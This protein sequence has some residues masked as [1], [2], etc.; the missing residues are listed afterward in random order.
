MA[1]MDEEAFTVPMPLFYFDG[2]PYT[3]VNVSTNGFITFGSYL[4]FVDWN[5]ISDSEPYDGVVAAFSGD[6]DM[7]ASGTRNIRC[8]Q[9]GNEFVIQWQNVSRYAVSGERISFQIR[10]NSA[11]G[12]I[13]VVYGGTITPGDDQYY[14][15]IG[16]RG[17]DNTF[18]TNVNN[19]EVLTGPWVSSAPGVDRFSTLVFD[20][21]DP[22]AVPSAGTTFT[23]TPA[24]IDMIA[25]SLVAPGTL[26]CYGTNETVTV[27]I[28]NI[29]SAIMNFATT[30]VTVNASASGPNPATFAPVVVNTG[31]L[32]PGA[33]QTVV[34]TTT[35][36]MS[37]AG[38]YSFDASV[39]V[40][41]D[42]RP[43][44]DAMAT[45]M[46]N[47]H[48]PTVAMT[49]NLSMCAGG[50]VT[51]NANAT[52]HDYS[53]AFTNTTAVAIPDEDPV[54]VNSTIVIS[55]Q[56]VPA[57]SVAVV[58]H[59]IQHSYISD[60]TLTLTAPD[61]ST[62][63]LFLEAGGSDPDMTE[64]RFIASAVTPISTGTAPFTGDYLPE[65]PF[66]QLTGLANGTWT[67]NVADNYEDD[68]GSLLSWSIEI[69]VTNVISTYAWSPAGS[70]S[71]S[72]VSN[73]DASPSATETYT[74][75]VT[76]LS[77][78]T[79][80][81]EV[82]V[83]V[84]ALPTVSASAS[85]TTVCENEAVTFNGSG[86]N[87]YAWTGGV[88][89]NVPFPVTVTDTYTVTGTDA[90]GCTDTDEITVTVIP[91][92]TVIATA[93]ATSVCDGTPVT[94]TG[95]GT[96]TTYTWDNS[97]I[98]ATPFTPT[99][100]TTYVVTGEDANGCE[101]T[102]MITVTVNALPTV[103]ATASSTSVCD[104]S[105]VTLTGTG[106]ATT[107]TWDNSV[108]DATP[109][110]PT[111]TATYMVT[112]ED[113]NG[114]E[115]T[116]MIT[117]TVNTLPA[118]TATADA[119]TV[120]EGT[121]VTLTGTGTATSYTW[122]NSV[123]DATPF[124]PTA[125]ATYMVTG[126]DANGCTATDMI[127]V[128]VNPA[129][130][131][132][133]SL[134]LDTVC[135]NVGSVTLTGETPAGGTWSGPGV[136]GNSLDPVAAG[137]GTHDIVYTYTDVNGCIGSDTSSVVVDVCSGIAESNGSS[138]LVYPNPTSGVFTIELSETP[139]APVTVEVINSLGQTVDA[140]TMSSTLK[141]VDL[142]QEESGIYFVRVINGSNTSTIRVVKQ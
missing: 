121:P 78:C 36:D 109:F 97:V 75:V 47:S 4:P 95:T 8:V 115:A 64:T 127:T 28:K 128:T 105:P 41:G 23:W 11:T 27:E 113:A 123:T 35:Y 5:P 112:G 53:I 80:S 44:N 29:G 119:T 82:T 72:T 74:V 129:P 114:C 56:P 88:L 6:I 14:P 136:T 92:P 90:N 137:T 32:A 135:T 12:E 117:V 106:T 25:T 18:A 45:A 13:K 103:T 96:A 63:I 120:C 118:V 68:N 86:A 107:Y 110:T 34:I 40:A 91:A 22:T 122:D 61:G 93:S 55:N 16:L 20:S 51:L 83:D 33:T 42:A 108:I 99:A 7:A 141:Q 2:A 87:Q 37:V 140:F 15:E 59:G 126:Q 134:P 62:M 69:P 26:G 50:M 49:S 138:S 43:Q 104:G 21:N 79:N 3:S 9:V 130:A 30:P 116:D 52:A 102:D 39:S 84:H 89:D 57:S 131:V 1:N 70:L 60:L 100:T 81:G 85:A 48:T 73:P 65:E 54:G 19:R 133:V 38:Q 142:S 58:I 94:L 125:T 67:L 139:S 17:P 71:S 132:T 46:R 66:S 31:T 101:A 10:L 24:P 77:G 111:A 98:D 76:D 124:T